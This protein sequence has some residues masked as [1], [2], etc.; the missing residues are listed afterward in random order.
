[1]RGLRQGDPLSP[2]LFILVRETLS[3]LVIRANEAGF[4]EGMH[5]NCS[6]W[7]D[8]LISCLLFVDDTL[9]FCNPCRS[10]LGYMKCVLVLFEVMSGLKVNLSNSV[11]IHVGEVLLWLWC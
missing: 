9:I 2:L 4:L 8:V 7:E 3:R 5:I 6:C 10:N 11:V 1:M